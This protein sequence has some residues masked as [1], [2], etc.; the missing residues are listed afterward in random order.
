MSVWPSVVFHHFTCC[1]LPANI[2]VKICHLSSLP[3]ILTRKTDLKYYDK[4][5][6]TMTNQSI[7]QSINQSHTILLCAQKLAREL[8][9]FECRK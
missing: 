5:Y 6:G 8:A 1:L 4:T 2:V 3:K 9:N 7:N